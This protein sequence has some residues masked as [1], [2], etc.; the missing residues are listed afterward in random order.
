MT[1]A[2]ASGGKH[3]SDTSPRFATRLMLLATLILL[4]LMADPTDA[5]LGLTTTQLFI[6][7]AI[8]LT[9]AGGYIVT[10]F[11]PQGG[12]NWQDVLL[13]IFIG[14]VFIGGTSTSLTSGD[15][16]ESFA[17]LSFMSLIYFP[18][19]L[20]A[21]QQ[22][23]LDWFVRRL[24]FWIVIVGLIMSVELIIWKVSG[25]FFERRAGQEHI[26]HEEIF[27]LVVASIYAS[28]TMTHRPVL[29]VLVIAMLIAGEISSFKN[30][31]F[32]ATFLTIALLASLPSHWVDVTPKRHAM[33]HAIVLL[34]LFLTIAVLVI[35]LPY[36]RDALPGG[37]TNVRFYT[38]SMRWQQFLDAPFFGMHFSGTPLIDVPMTNLHIP[39]HSDLLDLLAYGGV[40][41]AVLFGLPLLSFLFSFG[42]L[43]RVQP[44][45]LVAVFSYALVSALI[46]VWTFNPVWL[47]PQIGAFLWIGLAMCSGVRARHLH[48]SKHRPGLPEA[49]TGEPGGVPCPT[50]NLRHRSVDMMQVGWH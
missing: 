44:E 42:E 8:A 27:L 46:V 6:P 17:R 4:V 5:T 18:F 7:A 22:N 48:H 28:M 3:F 43:R 40:I 10:G 2:R 16:T 15:L 34:Y 20:L 39:S 33:R 13:G 36:F 1:A 47:Q 12:G 32:I 24:G 30:T 23:E 45:Q 26:Y 50:G 9:A 37:S 38:Y 31:G 25:P 14:F 21:S 29:R 35:L 19:R 49:P 11:K 41:G